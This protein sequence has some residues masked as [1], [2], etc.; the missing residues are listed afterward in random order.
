MSD[1]AYIATMADLRIVQVDST[2]TEPARAAARTAVL[3]KHGV[4]A[5]QL[6]ATATAL[7]ANPTHVIAVWKAIDKR[8]T[9]QAAHV[10]PAAPS[11]KTP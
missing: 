10:P 9:Q 7:A 1:A 2:L 3:A 5:D 4:S 8:L 6:E 11:P